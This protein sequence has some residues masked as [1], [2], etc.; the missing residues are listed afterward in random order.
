VPGVNRR[1][2][3]V[4]SGAGFDDW[5]ISRGAADCRDRLGRCGRGSLFF[6][7]GRL[8]DGDNQH[9]KRWLHNGRIAGG[10]FGKNKPDDIPQEYFFAKGYCPPLRIRGGTGVYTAYERGKDADPTAVRYSAS[11][12]K[13]A[14]ECNPTGSGL[15]IKVGV[16]GRAVA[17]PKG[18]AGS[19]TLP[20]RVVVTR[21]D[22][23]VAY[24]Q[25]FKLG[26]NLQ[27]PDLGA[28]FQQTITTIDLPMAPNERDVT[29]Y[30]GFD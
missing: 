4:G 16:A 3:R 9:R 7:R 22:N 24:S 18:A 23:S 13:T 21:A 5:P 14:R 12:G 10:L 15:A 2:E 20:V 19:V 17:G 28:D 8:L 29:I 11:I 1:E 6:D 25:L 30:V 27:P 26:E